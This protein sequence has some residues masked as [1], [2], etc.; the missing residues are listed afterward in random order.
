ML[1][2]IVALLQLSLTACQISHNQGTKGATLIDFPV[3]KLREP[4][5]ICKYPWLDK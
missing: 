2:N 1:I 4:L 5:R 3:D